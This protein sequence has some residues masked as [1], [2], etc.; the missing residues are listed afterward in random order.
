[1]AT[2][3]ACGPVEV[4]Y[5]DVI[6]SLILTDGTHPCPTTVDNRVISNERLERVLKEWTI[7]FPLKFVRVR[8]AVRLSCMWRHSFDWRNRQRGHPLHRA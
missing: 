1:M 8:P 2:Y 3:Y 6:L 7:S 5:N 4:K